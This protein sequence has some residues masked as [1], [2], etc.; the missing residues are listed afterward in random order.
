MMMRTKS[1]AA[2]TRVKVK[3]P[4]AVPVDSTWDDDGQRTSTPVKRRLQQLFFKGDKRVSASV[5]Y[6]SSET[7][8]ARLK[9]RKQVKVELRDAAG[10]SIVIVAPSENL[11]AA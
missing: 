1:M 5:V 7:L 6:V 8:R 2:G 11:I 10:A 3:K 4:G 9:N